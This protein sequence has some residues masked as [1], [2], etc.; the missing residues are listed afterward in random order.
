MNSVALHWGI[1]RQLRDAL[2]Q[3]AKSPLDAK[4]YDIMRIEPYS[5]GTIPVEAKAL[6]FNLIKPCNLQFP[7][8][9]LP[10]LEHP[11]QSRRLIL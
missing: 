4:Y 7:R 1:C 11:F 8:L 9:S 2:A 10:E 5:P 6:Q 3:P